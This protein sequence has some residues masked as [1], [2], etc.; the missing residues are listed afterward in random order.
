MSKEHGKRRDR[1]RIESRDRA[2]GYLIGGDARLSSAHSQVEDLATD[3]AALAQNL[4]LV[5]RVHVNLARR[6]RRRLLLRNAC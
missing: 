6:T 1:L 2:L 3:A 5:R 4:D